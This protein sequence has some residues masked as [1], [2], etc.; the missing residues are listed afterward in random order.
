MISSIVIPDVQ[1]NRDFNA[2]PLAV[3]EATSF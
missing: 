1:P 3:E 2:F